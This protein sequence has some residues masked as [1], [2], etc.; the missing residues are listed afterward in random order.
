MADSTSD[1]YI[2]A[3][4]VVQNDQGLEDIFQGLIVGITSLQG[5]MVRPRWQNEPPPLPKISENWCAFGV[6]NTRSD[7]GPYFQQNKEDMD[8]IR[9]E[10]I[11]V[12]LSFYGPQG[13]HYANL[14][15]D[16]LGIPQNIAQIRAHKIKFTGCGEILTAPDFLN[17]QYVHRYDMTATFN[18]QVKRSYAIETFESFQINLKRN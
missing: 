17:N 8:N 7:D 6:K 1:G 3:S 11:E 12:L 13:Q 16:G 14:L 9:H 15:K 18:R 10:S 5:K 2:P 4:G